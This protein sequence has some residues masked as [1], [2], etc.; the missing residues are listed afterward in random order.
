M[1][2]LVAARALSDHFDR[3]TLIERDRFPDGPDARKGVP[4]IRHVH[5]LLERGKRILAGYFP[6]LLEELARD[7]AHRI[8]M[9]GDTRWF[10]YGGWKPRFRSGM[11]FYC[12][13][14]PFLEWKVRARVAAIANVEFAEETDVDG[15]S[16]SREDPRIDGVWVRGKDEVRTLLPCDFV[17]DASG[18][19]SRMP[20]WLEAVG[21]QTPS[22]STVSVDVGYAS[23]SYR[24]RP[25]PGRDWKA[26]FIYH[27]APGKRL[28][29]VIPIENDRVMVTQVGW[30]RDYPASDD[31]GFLD[32]ARSLARSDVFDAI[33]D[34]EPCSPIAVH[35]FPANRRRHYERLADFPR[36]L[37]VVGDAL[38]SFNPIYGQG[39]TMAALAATTLA[40]AFAQAGNDTERLDAGRL[41]HR[42]FATTLDGIWSQST[43]EDLRFPEAVG[44]RPWW[45]ALSNRYSA[46]VYQASLRDE[47]VSKAFLQVMHL[48]EPPSS[49]LRPAILARVLRSGARSASPIGE[50]NGCRPG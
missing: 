29:V 12:Q 36:G 30:F 24:L 40:D 38:C 49:L 28:A 3:V 21:Q 20:P 41:F 8:D 18:R 42:R 31:A 23:R 37:A 11:E 5:V 7:G 46:R 33:R 25:D 32:F 17:V 39:M 47:V 13:S 16:C 22:E 9:A 48:I 43:S 14:R 50:E 26:L 6:G 34:A 45:L 15:L 35:R 10:H 2:G 4:Q 1:A 44:E 19:G 27:Q